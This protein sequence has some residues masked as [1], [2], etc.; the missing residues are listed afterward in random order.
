MELNSACSWWHIFTWSL[1]SIISQKKSI[2]IAKTKNDINKSKRQ[3]RGRINFLEFL[4]GTDFKRRYLKEE[5]VR[6]VKYTV[7][8]LRYWTGRQAFMDL[9]KVMN[10]YV[11]IHTHTYVHRSVTSI[12]ITG[13]A[14]PIFQCLEP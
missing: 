14:S 6:F 5:Q 12:T 9:E 4:K 10:I 1:F 8:R 2:F 7:M 13:E 11:R 3:K